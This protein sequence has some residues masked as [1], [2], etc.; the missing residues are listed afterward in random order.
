VQVGA[1]LR[2]AEA[3]LALDLDMIEAVRE[4][5]AFDLRTLDS[6]GA[7]GHQ[8]QFHAVCLEGIDGLMRARENEHLFFAIGREAVGQS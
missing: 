3:M 2:F 4:R 7:V 5:K 1:L 6:G 8:R